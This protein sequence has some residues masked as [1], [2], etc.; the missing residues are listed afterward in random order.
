MLIA[1]ICVKSLV[2]DDD[3]DD[4]YYYYYYNKG[5]ISRRLEEE[6]FCDDEMN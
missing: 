1:R 5:K 3:D 2:D 4:Y 6:R